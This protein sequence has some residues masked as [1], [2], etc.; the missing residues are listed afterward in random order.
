MSWM[1]VISSWKTMMTTDTLTEDMPTDG[2]TFNRPENSGNTVNGGNTV[3]TP[4]YE[5]KTSF[6]PI[7]CPP[8]D[9]R[10]ASAFCNVK[11]FFAQNAPGDASQFATHKVAP[12]NV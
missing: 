4:G 9:A 10:E 6:P 1:T 8:E 2:P 3:P 11:L 7:P 5:G 12:S